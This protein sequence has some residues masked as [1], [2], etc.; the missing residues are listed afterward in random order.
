MVNHS[1]EDGWTPILSAASSGQAALVSFLISTG[2]TART[3]NSAKRTP[4]HYAASKGL[5]DVISLLLDAGAVHWITG[6]FLA[7]IL[8]SSP[9]KLFI[10]II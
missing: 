1:D 2:A 10:F 5:V 8:V 7:E 9:G 6:S 3:C 4:L